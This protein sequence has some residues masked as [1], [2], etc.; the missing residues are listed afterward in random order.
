MEDKIITIDQLRRQIL[1]KA[2]NKAG[3]AAGAAELM[4]IS[5]RTVWRWKRSYRV[6]KDEQTGS[7][8]VAI[9]HRKKRRIAAFVLIA[10]S[11]TFIYSCCPAR[12]PHGCYWK[13]WDV[14]H[15]M[16]A[17]KSTPSNHQSDCPKKP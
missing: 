10:L 5:E 8:R 2:L 9:G 17:A 12:D 14:P 3:T 15:R 7:Y 6:E 16:F 4:G 1:L 13:P 11:L